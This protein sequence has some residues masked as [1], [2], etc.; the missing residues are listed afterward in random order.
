MQCHNF[1]INLLEEPMTSKLAAPE[2]L[3]ESLRVLGQQ[4]QQALLESK[5]SMELLI[6]LYYLRHGFES[7]DAIMVHYLS[8]L[9]FSIYAA[10]K[11]DPNSLSLQA[12]R[13]TIVLV[14]L[15]LRDQTQSYYLGQLVLSAVRRGMGAD[16]VSLIDR[17]AGQ[18]P[19]SEPPRDSQAQSIWTVDVGTITEKREN[20]PVL[21]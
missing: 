17:F 15:G 14:A 4:P 12:L 9:A 21:G 10:I 20:R 2:I 5:C 18:A 1:F 3:D 16:E 13:S 6:R 7:V 19:K 11:S 8:L